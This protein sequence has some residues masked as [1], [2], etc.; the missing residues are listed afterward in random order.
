MEGDMKLIWKANSNQQNPLIISNTYR[1]QQSSV[2]L[3]PHPLEKRLHHCSVWSQLL[4]PE[5]GQESRFGPAS[6]Q[7]GLIHSFCHHVPTPLLW[8]GKNLQMVPLILLSAASAKPSL[9]CCPSKNYFS[10]CLLGESTCL[11]YFFI[12]RGIICRKLFGYQ[13]TSCLPPAPSHF[14]LPTPPFSHSNDFSS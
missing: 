11:Q 1:M 2:K 12:C 8:C 5:W 9:W 13:K 6:L 4:C 7:V 14:V 3:Y 10:F